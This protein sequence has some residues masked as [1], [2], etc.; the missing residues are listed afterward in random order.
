[1][2]DHV[3]SDFIAFSPDSPLFGVTAND[4]VNNTVLLAEFLHSIVSKMK[5]LCESLKQ[6]SIAGNSLASKMQGAGIGGSSKYTGCVS[7]II[8]HFGGIIGGISSSQE[9]LA[10]CLLNTFVRPLEE[11]NLTEVSKISALQV[12]YKKENQLNEDSIM[13]YLQIDSFASY[14]MTRTMNQALVGMRALDVVQQRKKFELARF[15]FVRGVNAVRAQKSFEI[16]EACINVLFALRSHHRE[17]SERLLSS[18]AAL[19]EMSEQQFEARTNFSLSTLPTDSLRSNMTAVLDTMV[20]RVQTQLPQ[21]GALPPISPYENFQAV[22]QI[23]LLP[24]FPSL[25]MVGADLNVSAAA[26]QA[27]SRLGSMGASFMG[28]FGTA[29]PTQGILSSGSFDQERRGS[30]VAIAV[31]DKTHAAPGSLFIDIELRMKAL[32]RH[33]LEIFYSP[34][35]TEEY[36]GLIKQ[37]FFIPM[38]SLT[39]SLTPCLSFF[40]SFFLSSYLTPSMNVIWIIYPSVFG[41]TI[42]MFLAV[43]ILPKTLSS[44]S[45]HLRTRDIFCK[46]VLRSFSCLILGAGSGSY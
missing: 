18:S 31:A 7:P 12:E 35:S 23:N 21:L 4:S 9:L 36:S 41:I 45:S 27:I 38:P 5:D 32:D 10:E 2:T 46:E 29:K 8:K 11:F 15:D 26:S 3:E 33:Q 13:R 16:A 19:N 1:M 34:Y 30:A 39:H 22:D 17:S 42:K 43:K 28:G 6:T 37:V 44:L 20:E 40:L 14:T 25:S 24:D